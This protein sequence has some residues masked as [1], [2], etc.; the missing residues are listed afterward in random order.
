[1]NSE[2]F[3]DKSAFPLAFHWYFGIQSVSHEEFR[4]WMYSRKRSTVQPE[5]SLSPWKWAWSGPWNQHHRSSYGFL[6]SVPNELMESHLMCSVSWN[7]WC[8]EEIALPVCW[9]Q[10]VRMFLHKHITTCLFKHD[11]TIFPDSEVK[12]WYLKTPLHKKINAF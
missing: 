8:D 10:S 9:L 3:T 11:F 12:G 4:P 1:M 6:V 2:G 5:T 7:G